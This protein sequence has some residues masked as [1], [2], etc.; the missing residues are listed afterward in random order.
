MINTS[1]ASKATWGDGCDSW[2]LLDECDLHV[3]QERLPAG[4]AEIW[5]RHERVR[6]LYYVLSGTAIVRFDDRDEQL[7]PGDAVEVPPGTA[8]QLRN[9]GSGPLELLVISSSAPR[10]D[11]VDLD[12]PAR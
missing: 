10:A 1:N 2:A 4:G 8:H 7:G 6:Q 5:H 12:Q 11:R 3:Q 9:D